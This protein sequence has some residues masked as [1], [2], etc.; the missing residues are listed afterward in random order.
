MLANLV[1][2]ED[3]T[4]NTFDLNGTT[5]LLRCLGSAKI[6]ISHS[7]GV[8]VSGDKRI[9]IVVKLLIRVQVVFVHL[10]LHIGHVT[11]TVE[12]LLIFHLSR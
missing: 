5:A 8:R 12:E 3:R 1:L 2:V 11:N 10:F 9:L 4:A 6:H 7:F